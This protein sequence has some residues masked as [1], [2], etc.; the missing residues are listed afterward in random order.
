MALLSMLTQ[1]DTATADSTKKGTDAKGCSSLQS[2]NK[3]VEEPRQSYDEKETNDSTVQDCTAA[4]SQDGLQNSVDFFQS[5]HSEGPSPNTSMKVEEER[6]ETHMKGVSRWSTPRRN[7]SSDEAIQAA[8]EVGERAADGA[9]RVTRRQKSSADSGTALPAPSLAPP[10][11]EG[12]LGKIR[13]VKRVDRVKRDVND[14]SPPSLAPPSLASDVPP[15]RAGRKVRRGVKKSS[16]RPSSEK[17][18]APPSLCED[19]IAGGGKVRRVRRAKSD[20]SAQLGDMSV[21]P[22]SLAGDQLYLRTTRKA[23]RADE[24]NNASVDETDEKHLKLS[25]RQERKA[26]RFSKLD[27]DDDD[28]VGAGIPDQTCDSKRPRRGM[29]TK[30]KSAVH[31]LEKGSKLAIKG[32]KLAR[33]AASARNLFK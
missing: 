13:R 11:L 5:K 6:P 4:K 30:A 7:K 3:R 29:L 23:G 10:S 12:N 15:P 28:S 22:P 1:R 19:V 32:S 24:K 25:C 26:K 17:S 14:L 2:A 27:S 20:S 8:G 16:S 21:A 18:L 9:R 33:K 31:V